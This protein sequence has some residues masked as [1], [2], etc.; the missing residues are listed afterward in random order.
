MA[1]DYAGDIGPRQ[2]WAMLAEEP[3]AVLVDVRTDAEWTYV[4]LPDLNSIGKRTIGVM[5]KSYPDMA[6]NEGFDVQ[7]EL[8]R[9]HPQGGAVAGRGRA[10][11]MPLGH[12]LARGGDRVDRGGVPALLQRRRR[13][14]GTVRRPEPPRCVVGLEGRRAALGAELKK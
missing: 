10:V 3:D 7:R 11:A 6:V 1:D 4:G 9:R 2:A 14:R 13:V 12:T 8:R 5:W